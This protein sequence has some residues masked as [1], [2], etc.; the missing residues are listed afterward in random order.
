M[1]SLQGPFPSLLLWWWD[2]PQVT[3]CR[4][5]GNAQQPA[6]WLDLGQLLWLV[7]A[8]NGKSLRVGWGEFHQGSR[9]PL[10]LLPKSRLEPAAPRRL[11]AGPKRRFQAGFHTQPRDSGR[12]GCHRPAL[13]THQ[14]CSKPKGDCRAAKAVG[15]SGWFP[16]NTKF[17]LGGEFGCAVP[18]FTPWA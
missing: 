5:A 13:G 1:N 2:L 10:P 16:G 8:A 3:Q 12:A 17:M 6:L 18:P 9:T 15:T 14:A 11:F 7:S 4:G